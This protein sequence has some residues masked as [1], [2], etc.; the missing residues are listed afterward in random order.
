MERAHRCDAAL[1]SA[2]RL[3]L[4]SSLNPEMRYD[5]RQSIFTH[6]ILLEVSMNRR[7]ILMR[8][9][10]A[11]GA[12][13]AA[14]SLLS[15]ISASPALAKGSQF[16]KK[17]AAD[18]MASARR[19]IQTGLLCADHC[20]EMLGA[21]QKD[22]VDCLKSVTDLVASCEA[23]EKLA[24]NQ[25]THLGTLAKAAAVICAD[26]AKTCEPYLQ[27]MQPCKDCYDACKECEKLC[28]TF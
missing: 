16:D 12:V 22:M 17:A 6:S 28:K 26:C 1:D 19:C 5:R 9:A 23:L 4:V 2:A 25:S 21:G 7:E 24:A 8:G 27:K 20:I 10:G 11:L 15:A 14:E 13:A 3:G 18:L